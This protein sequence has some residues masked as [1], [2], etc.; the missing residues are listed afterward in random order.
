MVGN[1]GAIVIIVIAMHRRGW[2]IE[3]SLTECEL[4]SAVAVGEEAIVANAMEAVRQYVDAG[5]VA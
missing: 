4:V 5:S 3:Q 1:A 2:H